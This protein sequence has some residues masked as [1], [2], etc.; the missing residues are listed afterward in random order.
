MYQSLELSYEEVISA[1]E[2]EPLRHPE[3][4][5]NIVLNMRALLHNEGDY[6]VRL[7]IYSQKLSIAVD[8]KHAICLIVL[9]SLENKSL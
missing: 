8:P 3:R 2:I 7:H 9:H 4:K 6:F 5:S 1:W